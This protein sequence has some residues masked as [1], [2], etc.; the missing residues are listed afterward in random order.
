MREGWKGAA[1]EAEGE[2]A[3]SFEKS[4]TL[5]GCKRV[6]MLR[7]GATGATAHLLGS[8]PPNSTPR[9]TRVLTLADMASAALPAAE[10]AVAVRAADR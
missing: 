9:K 5:I 2:E 7:S 10:G 6:R 4:T 1:T 8:V 3:V